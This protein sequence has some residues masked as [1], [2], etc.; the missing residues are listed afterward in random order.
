MLWFRD[1]IATDTREAYWD[2][3]ARLTLRD[4]LDVLQKNLTIVIMQYDK[5]ETDMKKSIEQWMA[6]HQHT[7]K[8]W[9]NILSMLYASTSIDDVMFFI[10]LRE[11]TD[12]I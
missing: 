5:K 1:R 4:E 12:L 8:R 7:I 3:L 9:E 6:N 2:T 11:L 10:A